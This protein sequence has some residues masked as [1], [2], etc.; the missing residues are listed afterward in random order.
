MAAKSGE[1]DAV[2]LIEVASGDQEKVDQ[3]ADAQNAESAKVDGPGNRFA[4]I[5][6]VRSGE[7]DDPEHITD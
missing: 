6:T 7:T 5:E 3:P 1:R 2:Y 4:E